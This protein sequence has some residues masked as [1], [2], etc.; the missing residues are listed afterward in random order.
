MEGPSFSR[1]ERGSLLLPPVAPSGRS[2]TVRKR[3]ITGF[4]LAHFV[5]L[6]ERPLGATG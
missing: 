5:S 3:L 1:P 4:P 6:Y 2:Y